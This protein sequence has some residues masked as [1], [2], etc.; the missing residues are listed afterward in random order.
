MDVITLCT[1]SAP[2]GQTYRVQEKNQKELKTKTQR[3]TV[4]PCSAF[5][6]IQSVPSGALLF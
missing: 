6:M 1:D 2:E 5:L 4:N 3:R